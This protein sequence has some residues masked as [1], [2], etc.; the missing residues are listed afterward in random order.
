MTINSTTQ[1]SRFENLSRC[2]GKDIE[3]Y[4][5]LVELILQQNKDVEYSFM[6]LEFFDR[7]ARKHENVVQTN[8]IYWKEMLD[9]IHLASCTSLRRNMG[10]MD[11]VAICE[12]SNSFLG[13]TATLRALIESTGDS[14]EV[15]AT[16]PKNVA[17]DYRLIRRCIDGRQEDMFVASGEM[18]DELIG[19]SHGRHLRK[20]EVAPKS[21]VAKQAQYYVNWLENTGGLL[22]LYI[23]CC[24]Q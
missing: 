10:W 14:A 7:F 8:Q 19:Y 23:A 6:P 1:N 21:H 11:A 5:P 3:R 9:R 18:E 17:K 20:G 15:L 4:I 12:V 13:F 16:M 22:L 2:F 24:V